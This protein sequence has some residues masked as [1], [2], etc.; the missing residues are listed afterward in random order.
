MSVKEIY[1]LPQL[2]LEDLDIYI[3]NPDINIKDMMGVIKQR[4]KGRV[5]FN[6]KE[7]GEYVQSREQELKA[8][9]L[10]QTDIIPLPRKSDTEMN[11][12]MDNS[13]DKSEIVN[14]RDRARLMHLLK[15]KVVSRMQKLERTQIVG[16]KDNIDP[17]MEQLLMNYTK[18]LADLIEKEVR[19]QLEVEESSKLDKMVTERINMAMFL[20]VKAIKNLVKPKEFEAFQKRVK[21]MFENYGIDS[22]EFTEGK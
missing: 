13:L 1:L 14:V 2:I 20:V 3:N 4:Y 8:P 17:Y 12:S 5:K 15:E 9:T 22:K 21:E 6:I 11:S 19:L 18:V 10:D 7:L 16:G